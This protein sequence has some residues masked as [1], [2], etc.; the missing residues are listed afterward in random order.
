MRTVHWLV[1]ALHKAR[2]EDGMTCDEVGRCIGRSGGAV[3]AWERG[4]A[5]PGLAQVEAWAATHD[6]Y[7]ALTPDRPAEA[8]LAAQAAEVVL[9]ATVRHMLQTGEARRIREAAGL[10]LQDAGQ[11]AGVD[12]R[13]IHKWETGSSRPQAATAVLYGRFLTELRKALGLPREAGREAS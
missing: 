2:L 4:E 5:E 3:S 8:P 7:V 1:A 13:A 11:A 12:Q 10:S 6:L 9:V